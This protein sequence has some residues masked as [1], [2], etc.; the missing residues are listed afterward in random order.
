MED[1]L[2]Q[3]FNYASITLY[4]NYCRLDEKKQSGNTFNDDLDELNEDNYFL[5]GG[6]TVTSGEFT[7]NSSVGKIVTIPPK[8][9][10][11]KTRFFYSN[12]KTMS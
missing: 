11:K 2:T 3:R 7:G 6:I 5:G 10:N 9:N 8:V 4:R 1:I 12:L